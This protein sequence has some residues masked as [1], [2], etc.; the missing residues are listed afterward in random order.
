MRLISSTLHN[1]PASNWYREHQLQHQSSVLIDGSPCTND[2]PPQLGQF[3]I[4]VELLSPWQ[5]PD[6]F[7]RPYIGKLR[8]LHFMVQCCSASV[9]WDW[10]IL[11]DSFSFWVQILNCWSSIVPKK[12]SIHST[13][14]V[15]TYRDV[16]ITNEHT[17]TNWTLF[18]STCNL[19]SA[20]VA[21][22]FCYIKAAMK[23]LYLIKNE[24]F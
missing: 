6:I 10:V 3:H 13:I 1:S 4:F 5:F 7:Y 12:I 17:L 19:G 2:G 11:P 16:N 22:M 8:A 23:L 9:N 15:F 20:I 21:C 18:L 24:T 14:H